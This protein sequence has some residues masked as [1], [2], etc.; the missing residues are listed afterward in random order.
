MELDANLKIELENDK[1]GIQGLGSGNSKGMW[2][3]KDALQND[4]NRQ[5]EE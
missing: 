1:R 5:D 4:R 2:N 3:F